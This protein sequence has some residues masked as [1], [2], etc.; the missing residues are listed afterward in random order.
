MVSAQLTTMATSRTP[1]TV[2]STT[3]ARRARPKSSV[4]WEACC[5]IR[6]RAIVFGRSILTVRVLKRL[7]C[8]IGSTTST[9]RPTMK[10]RQLRCARRS[11]APLSVPSTRQASSPILTTARRT[12]SAISA[13][14]RSCYVSLVCFIDTTSRSVTGKSTLTVRRGVLRTWRSLGSSTPRAAVAT[15]SASMSA[16][17]FSSVSI[18]CCST[19][20]PSNAST[21]QRS[22]VAHAK[23][24]P[25]RV[26][27]LP[28]RIRLYAK[29][30]PA[31]LASRRASIWTRTA[32]TAS[33]STRVGMIACLITPSAPST[34]D[35]I[36]S[37]ADACQP[38]MS[39]AAMLEEHPL[40][41]SIP[42][43]ISYLFVLFI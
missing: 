41:K 17:L 18:Q 30:F 35:S 32:P 19:R 20:R 7:H 1:K 8:R 22:S 6:R 14:T 39:S 27:T 26:S 12:I 36:S 9:P 10:R 31:A 40:A 4:V 43:F 42:L 33:T 24:A 2:A 29:W 23:N 25:I 28:M 13:T 37:R 34:C 21:T 16:W 11:T 38:V 3:T 15:L 5:G